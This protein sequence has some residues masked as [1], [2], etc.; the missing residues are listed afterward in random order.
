MG[1]H[2][3]MDWLRI[4]AFGLLIFYHIGM[5]FVPWG[6]H[7]KTAQPIDWVAV[8]MQAVNAWRLSLLFVVSGYASRA[9]FDRQP[10][11]GRFAW[12]RTKRLIPPLLFAIVLIVPPQPWVELTTQRGYAGGLWQFWTQDYWQFGKLGG[13]VLPTWQH[14]WFIVYL[15]AYTVVLALVLAVT[16]VRL[17]DAIARGIAWALHGPM[18]LIVPAALLIAQ[19]A[20][21][22][23][24]APETHAFFDDLPIHRVYFAMFLFG[25]VLRESPALWASIRRWWPV[26]LA[27]GALGYGYVAWVQIAYPGNVPAPK[28]VWFAFGIAR[29]VQSWGM[30]VALIGIADR[31]LNIDHPARAML[32]EA[33]FPFYIIHQ[34]VIVLVAGALLGAGI[35]P[36]AEFAILLAATVAGCWLFYRLGRELDWL[37]PLIGLRAR[38]RAAAPAP[39]PVVATAQG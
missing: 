2:Y 18:L 33:V 31:W 15:W 35:G 36:L 32:N 14:L 22:F 26:A 9:I 4:G 38:R 8:P 39:A 23:P 34:T 30:I 37:R 13:L 7:A 12:G 1:R 20:W 19:M 28:D 3:G 21:L 5:V 29:A 25:F 10:A 16:P 6:F 17:G 24:G 27:M 11:A